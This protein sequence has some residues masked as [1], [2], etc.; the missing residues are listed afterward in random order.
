MAMAN[1]LPIV[2]KLNR[3][4]ERKL[5]ARLREKE[6]FVN[7]LHAITTIPNSPFLMGE[8][9]RGWTANFEWFLKPSTVDKLFEG[10]YGH[11]PIQDEGEIDHDT[12]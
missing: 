8:N 1:D 7:S 11:R 6:W 9:E 2:R 5:R 4:R 10:F 12:F 3:E